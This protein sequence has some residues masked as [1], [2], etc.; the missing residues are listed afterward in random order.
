MP[1]ARKP[2]EPWRI[3]ETGVTLRVRV[4]PNA[5]TDKIVGWCET[6]DGPALQVKVRAIPENGA[7]NIAVEKL[8]AKW[9]DLPKSCVNLHAGAKS[10][11]KLLHVQA[12]GGT[13]VHSL[14]AKTNVFGQGK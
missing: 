2:D 4:T 6:A 8:L 11:V 13:L 14:L 9:L 1:T 3:S 12:E 7:A 10:R 5:S